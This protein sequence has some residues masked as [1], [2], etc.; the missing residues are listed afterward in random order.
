LFQNG[1]S[2][3]QRPVPFLRAWLINFH[4]LATE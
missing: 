1:Q 3:Q 4:F 2:F